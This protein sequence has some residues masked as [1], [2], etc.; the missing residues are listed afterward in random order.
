MF[1]RRLRQVMRGTSGGMDHL[2]EQLRV[3]A[4]GGSGNT[5]G[6]EG[7]GFNNGAFVGGGSQNE[8]WG[9]QSVVVG[10]N[11]NSAGTYSAALGGSGNTASAY[12]SVVGGGN[13]IVLVIPGI[14]ARG[15]LRDHVV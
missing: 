9:H 14:A 12:S 15:L 7:T 6:N 1:V 13:Q 4:V 8:A 2:H 5:A 11:A 3:Q 10:G